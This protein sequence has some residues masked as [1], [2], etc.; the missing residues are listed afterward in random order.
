MSFRIH[1]LLAKYIQTQ[2]DFSHQGRN[3]S[4]TIT[5]LEDNERN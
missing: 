3:F 2:T 4:S 5:E 1:L